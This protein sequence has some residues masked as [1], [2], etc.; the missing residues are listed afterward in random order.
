MKPSLSL[1]RSRVLGT[2]VLVILVVDVFLKS[3]GNRQE[4]L[5][6]CYWAS[7]SVG[8]GMC[9]VSD[10]LVSA[11]VIFFAGLGIPGWLLGAI[12]D[13]RT[14]MISVLFHVVPLAVGF[15]YVST[16]SSLPKYSAALAWLLYGVPLG[17]AWQFCEPALSINLS[18]W[19]RWPVPEFLPDLWQ[20]YAM[21]IL[22]TMAMVA[23]MARIINSMLTRRGALTPHNLKLRQPSS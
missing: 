3:P 6:A 21:L 11:G 4:V 20:F 13:G 14:E 16:M 17:L 5:W 18:H 7:A 19:T 9:L 10:V 15:Y 12:I 2:G 1:G 8:I 23:W 22:V